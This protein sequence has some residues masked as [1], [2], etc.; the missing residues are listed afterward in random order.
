[1]RHGILL[2]TPQVVP[3]VNCY[4]CQETCWLSICSGKNVWCHFI[5]CQSGTI[6]VYQFNIH[7]HL[8]IPHSH[9]SHT[10]VYCTMYSVQCTVYNVQCTMY[11]VQC[12]VYNVQ[13][14]MYSVQCT[15]YNVQCTLY[16]VQCTLYSVQCTM[17]SVHC[18]EYTVHCTIYTVHIVSLSNVFGTCYAQLFKIFNNLPFHLQFKQLL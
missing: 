13:C 12:T 18:T 2:Q 16:N 1:M 14:T 8:H 3:E 4:L 11:S 17:Y 10:P 9:L 5:S 6:P 7:Q 15:V